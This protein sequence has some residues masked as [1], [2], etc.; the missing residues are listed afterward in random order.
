MKRQLTPRTNPL[1]VLR[2]FYDASRSAF[3][4][5]SI[6]CVLV[7]LTATVPLYSPYQPD[8]MDFMAPRADG[9]PDTPIGSM[10]HHTFNANLAGSAG[11]ERALRDFRG[12]FAFWISANRTRLRRGDGLPDR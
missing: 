11:I 6:I 5:S 4:G 9:Y 10:C 8:A 12:G 3:L 2:K 7:I 1:K